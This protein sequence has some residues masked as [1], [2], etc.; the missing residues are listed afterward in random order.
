MPARPAIF[1]PP[2]ARAARI[3]GAL[4]LWLAGCA[5]SAR[6]GD[7]SFFSGSF[8][9]P[10]YVQDDSGARKNLDCRATGET[11]KDGA[12][13]SQDIACESESYKFDLRGQY[14]ADGAEARGFW[15]EATR[16][17][18]GAV[19]AQIVGQGFA[20]ASEAKGFAGRFKLHAGP[21]KLLFT[22]WPE[23]GKPARV[24]AALARQRLAATPAAR[25]NPRQAHGRRAS[26]GLKMLN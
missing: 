13:L 20:G 4:A 6:A 5:V 18:S 26:A 10:G 22:F 23:D 3:G 11:A 25:E 8:R 9:G 12:V 15:R 2:V 24:H 1:P 14:V 7:L 17:S 21:R 19:A 16:G